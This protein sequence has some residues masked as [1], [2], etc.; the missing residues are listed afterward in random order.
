MEVEIDKVKMVDRQRK[1]L[2]DVFELAKSIEKL[3]QIQP[4]VID[5]KYVFY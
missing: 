4:I 2:G 5:D 1:D 3:G